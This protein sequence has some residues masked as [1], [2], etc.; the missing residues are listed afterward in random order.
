MDSF[1]R[2]ARAIMNS[3]SAI[4]NPKE[5]LFSGNNDDDDPNPPNNP[6]SAYGTAKEVV[7]N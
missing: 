1:G 5:D 2:D 4:K 6:I 3:L 7:N